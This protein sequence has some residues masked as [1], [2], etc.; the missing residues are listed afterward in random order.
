MTTQLLRHVLYILAA[1]TYNWWLVPFQIYNTVDPD[2]P[3]GVTIVA[4][5]ADGPENNVIE[6]GIVCDYGDESSS[7]GFEINTNGDLRVNTTMGETF[8]D[9]ECIILDR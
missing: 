9:Y 6:Y 8:Q 2:Q 4:T 3:S 1:N 5:D 7:F